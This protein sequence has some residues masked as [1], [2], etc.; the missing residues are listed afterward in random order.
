MKCGRGNNVKNRKR[1]RKRREE[2]GRNTERNEEGKK[3]EE[4]KSSSTSCMHEFGGG[5]DGIIVHGNLRHEGV[6]RSNLDVIPQ[7]PGEAPL[8][9]VDFDEKRITHLQ[10]LAFVLKHHH[11]VLI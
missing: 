4:V 11:S 10:I 9:P 3:R 2:R 6:S 7:S 8:G 1:K 5:R